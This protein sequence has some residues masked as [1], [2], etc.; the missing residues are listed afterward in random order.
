MKFWDMFKKAIGNI[1]EASARPCQR[2]VLIIIMQTARFGLYFL[3][4]KATLP[5]YTAVWP[6]FLTLKDVNRKVI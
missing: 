6:L 2:D 1:S 4:K 3:T 5:D